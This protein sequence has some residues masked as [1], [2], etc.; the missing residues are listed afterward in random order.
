MEG[1]GHALRAA[2]EWA[3]KR[4]TIWEG[5]SSGGVVAG[6]G[7]ATALDIEVNEAADEWARQAAENVGGP[8]TREYLRENSFAH[9]TR[10]ATEA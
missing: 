10:T 2:E 6:G 5:R 1:K 4:N 9:M 8:V 7:D 3:E